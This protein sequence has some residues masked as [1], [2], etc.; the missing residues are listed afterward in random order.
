[1][2]K[3]LYLLLALLG[4]SHSQKAQW[5]DP[6]VNEVSRL[7]MHTTF[8][9]ADPC[10]SLDGEWF[11]QWFESVPDRQ[12]DFY[13]TDIDDSS[14]NTIPVPGMWELNG[15]GDPVYVNHGYAWNGNAPL[16]PPTVPEKDNHVGQYRTRFNV[17]SDWK[18]RDVVLTIGSATSNVR[19]WVNGKEA[20]Y[21]E[22]SKLQADF[23]ITPYVKPGENLLAL[24]VFR[25]CDGTYLEDQDFWRLSGIARGVSLTALPRQ[26]IN[27]VRVKAGADGA[28][29]FSACITKGVRSLKFFVD[30]E[31]VPARGIWRNPRLWSA[32]IPNLYTLKVEAFDAKGKCHEVSLD[33]G[34]RTV[35]VV[36]N[37]L[38]VNGQPVLFKGVDRH[39][40]S[41]KGGY[42]LTREEME[43]D[44]T[45]MKRL[46]INAVRCSHYPNDPYWYSL[47]DRYG[48]YVIDE[49]NCES[50]GMGYKEKTLAIVTSYE[51]SHLERTERM[52][53]RD[54]NHPS[55]IIWSLGNEG[56]Y[57]PAFEKCYDLAKAMDSTR[58]VQYERA[59]LE[60]KSDIHC[61][62]YYSPDACR[63][64][65][66]NNP[67]KP[68]IMCE[69]S[70]AMGNSCG[71]FKEYWDLARK[72][73]V[74]QGGFIW[75]FVDQALRWPSG[76]SRTGYIYAFGGD[77]N[78]KDPSGNSFNCNGLIAADRSLHPHAYEVQY[79]Y[80]NIWASMDDPDSGEVDLKNEFF[81]RD[82]SNVALHWEMVSDGRVALSGE[83]SDL[84][85]APQRNSKVCIAP[86]GILGEMNENASDVWLNM[87]F[88]LKSDEGLQKAGERIAAAQI[89]LK[90]LPSDPSSFK[91]GKGRIRINP[92]T[93]AL[94]SWIVD[95]CQLLSSPVMPCF[96][97][98][99]TENDFGARY[100]MDSQVWQYPDFKLVSFK[101]G[102]AEYLLEG[103]CKVSMEYKVEDDGSICIRE[104][105]FDVA[106]H[107]PDMLR[108]GLEFAMPGSFGNLDF[109]GKGPYENY[110]DRASAARMGYYS[111][112]VSEQYHYA[113]VRPQESGTHTSMKW[114]KLSDD[115][116]R[117]LVVISGEKFSASALDISRREMD[118]SEEQ[119]SLVKSVD[120]NH[121]GK[122]FRVQAHSL[123]LGRDGLTHVNVDLVQNGVGGIDSW[124][125]KPLE[126]YRVKARERVFEI[127]MI[128]VF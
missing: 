108:F 105:M 11:F 73:P 1:M 121:S 107:S 61:P 7:P 54:F 124:S 46:N 37:Q 44:I 110:S 92:Q 118:L 3:S 15:Y 88:V 80:Q 66:E 120:L 125:S 47:C 97:R 82:L 52:I 33:F 86:R 119:N 106:P 14:W 113:Y 93:G 58:P 56:G 43:E 68:F 17:P 10:V 22:D 12:K 95:G 90:D 83:A 127:R 23:D 123:E 27:D 31:E 28:Y 103:L 57:G 72:Y 50:H 85:V 2:L 79:Q 101:D 100:N 48:L 114:M 26:R 89:V 39:E 21:S 98:A 65:L 25:W 4:A 104:R 76:K 20:G 51:K 78:R 115:G 19:V 111:Q 126:Q 112:K 128:P 94:D 60:G 84:D 53:Q 30:G 122:G 81:F 96:G 63:R 24:E 5:Q 9:S 71:G 38:Y 35:E 77:F 8:H 67:P 59:L 42:C 16:C 55:I 18:G 13:R 109:C 117:G 45:I 75:D 6:S 91:S 41:P 49:A 34:F 29:E 99:L 40:M 69:Y 36:G 64:Y 116:G 102:K 74:F 70:H 62:M 32:E 87:D